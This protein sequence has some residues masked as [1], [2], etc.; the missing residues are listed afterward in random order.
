MAIKVELCE[1][2]YCIMFMK[3]A[4]KLTKTVSTWIRNLFPYGHVPSPQAPHIQ[5]V[6]RNCS[7]RVVCIFTPPELY[8][9]KRKS[10]RLSC[11]KEQ[12][13]WGIVLLMEADTFKWNGTV[14]Q[15]K[16]YMDHLNII[17]FNNLGS[18]ERRHAPAYM[19]KGQGRGNHILDL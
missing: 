1:F 10:E 8:S 13:A 4:W 16:G 7:R 17:L 3:P 5:R 15:E 6:T 11:S 2:L 9:S 14:P 19:E 18:F 12:K